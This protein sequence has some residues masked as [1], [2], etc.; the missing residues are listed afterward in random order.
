VVD[1]PPDLSPLI[2]A[3]ADAA[4]FYALLTITSV[5]CGLASI[6]SSTI[7]PLS[8]DEIIIAMRI[9]GALITA[10]GAFPSAKYLQRKDKKSALEMISKRYEQLRGR[11]Y[12]HSPAR[13]DLDKMVVV[14]IKGML[15][16]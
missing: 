1:P 13:S 14:L 16:G 15:K 12:F 8:Q 11:E 10:L 7:F 3:Q 6:T 4:R 9:G 2:A 5:G